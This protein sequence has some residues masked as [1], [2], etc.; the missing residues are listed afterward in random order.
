V[1][2]ACIE[3]LISGPKL[4]PG[5]NVSLLNFS[6]KLN[7]ATKVLNGDVEREASVATDLRKIVNSLPNDLVAKWQTENYE[8]V[9]RH[10]TA[11]LQDIANFVKRQA[12]IRNEPVFG[13]QRPRRETNEEN[14][15]GKNSSKNKKVQP[16]RLK[17]STISSTQIEK[18]TRDGS[19]ATCAICK[20]APPPPTNEHEPEK[21]K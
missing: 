3:G 16:P 21:Q 19:S 7:A 9:S 5:D 10:R 8:I 6:E 18:P 1:S 20:S 14:K 4:F 13:S 12:S 15:D 17:D 2:Q 11:R